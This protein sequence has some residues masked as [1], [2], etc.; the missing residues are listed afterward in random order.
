MLHCAAWRFFFILPQRVCNGKQTS[1]D[2]A[3]RKPE[4]S[5]ERLHA[6]I[7]TRRNAKREMRSASQISLARQK[8]LVLGTFCCIAK[9]A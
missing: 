2:T 7:T 6:S 4:R 9:H 8:W 1:F 3:S 5:I